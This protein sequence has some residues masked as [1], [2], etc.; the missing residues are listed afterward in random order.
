MMLVCSYAMSH[1]HMIFEHAPPSNTQSSGSADASA[2]AWAV[3][4][5]ERLRV[6][7]DVREH[8]SERLFVAADRD[9][10]SAQLSCP[11]TS[12]V[13]QHAG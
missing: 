8:G 11:V 2:L 12:N 7:I 9:L 4:P 3:V 5:L 10:G 6:A 13:P 1:S